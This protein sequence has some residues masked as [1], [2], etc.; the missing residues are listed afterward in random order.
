MDTKASQ[1]NKPD[2]YNLL[3]DSVLEFSEKSNK[4]KIIYFEINSISSKKQKIY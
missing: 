3:P 1:E 4:E 2:L